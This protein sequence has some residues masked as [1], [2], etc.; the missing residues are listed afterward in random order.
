MSG[1]SRFDITRVRLRQYRSIANC[2]VRLGPLSLI[3]GPN[4]SGKSNFVDSLRLVS[5]ALNEN[6]DNA[7]R[8]RGGAAE[9][10]RRSTGHPTHFGIELVFQGES[11][12]GE[13]KFQIAAVRGG[14]FRVSHESCLV[15]GSEFGGEPIRYEIRDGQ[16][17]F[18]SDGVVVPR[19]T[20]DR[21]LLATLSG[22][23]SFRPVFDGLTG[24]NVFNLNPDSMRSLQKPDP[25]E[26]M[27]RDGANVASVLE[28]LKRTQP[29]LKVRIEEYLRQIVP[30]VESVDRK[31]L[32]AYETLEFRQR[33]QGSR[34]PWV[35][36][37]TSMSDGTLRVLGVLVALFGPTGEARSP[38]VVEEP[39][40]AL[41]P[42]AAG[43]L[44]EALKSASTL[45]QVV[46][47]THSPD[48][49][50]SP[51]L[52]ADEIVAVRAEDGKTVVSALEPAGH[53]AIKD[54]LYTPG[55]LL[56][57]DQLQPAPD[58]TV[59]SELFA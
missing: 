19:V 40:V 26:L 27:H 47:T 46:A 39:E 15:V 54:S 17:V 3:V 8:E 35:F 12:A 9:V 1:A 30:G 20:D 24:V 7:L 14:D 59:Q 18:A 4:G 43:L 22:Q 21:L 58:G 38:V 49:L 41:H 52:Q 13:Y 11:F 6:L 51:A 55:E 44:L 36:P 16:V 2:D 31:G 42:A 28:N 29:E 53:Q 56:R 5:Q 33:V 10:R 45:R 34:D 48:L 37:A 32:G 25:G 23:E 50:D 57:V